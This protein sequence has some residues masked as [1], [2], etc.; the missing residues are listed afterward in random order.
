MNMEAVR[1]F[2]SPLGLNA[3]SIKDTLVCRFRSSPG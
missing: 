2:L 1:G 3:G